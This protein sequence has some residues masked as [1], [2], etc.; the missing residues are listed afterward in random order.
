MNKQL[1]KDETFS[2]KEAEDAIGEDLLEQVVGGRG[3][4]YSVASRDRKRRDTS[5]ATAAAVAP[6][7]EAEP[8]RVFHG[9]PGFSE[10]MQALEEARDRAQ[11]EAQ[12]QMPPQHAQHMA[13]MAS[14]F[15]AHQAD[16]ASL[17][18]HVAEA[19][20][21]LAAEGP[22][23]APS[24]EGGQESTEF[25][26]LDQGIDESTSFTAEADNI[27]SEY[28]AGVETALRLD[29]SGAAIGFGL[30][31]SIATEMAVGSGVTVSATTETALSA[32]AEIM[33]DNG[34]GAELAAEASAAVA[35]E[36]SRQTDL[37]NGAS[38]D[39]SGGVEAFMG[40][41]GEAEGYVGDKGAKFGFDGTAG[42]EYT[43][44]T[45]QTLE[46]SQLTA[47]GEASVS[48]SGTV[49]MA[50]SAEATYEDGALT[51]GAGGGVDALLAGA[52]LGG[53]VSIQFE[54][55]YGTV[56]SA[57]EIRAVQSQLAHF[58]SA[59]DLDEDLTETWREELRDQ[60]KFAQHAADRATEEVE[61]VAEPLVAFDTAVT[62]TIDDLATR[63]AALAETQG[64]VDET[65][66]EL[67]AEFDSDAEF[68]QALEDMRAMESDRIVEAQS[69]VLRGNPDASFGDIARAADVAPSPEMERHFA[70]LEVDAPEP[71]SDAA[72]DRLRAMYDADR[73]QFEELAEFVQQEARAE[74]EATRLSFD[75]AMFTEYMGQDGIATFKETE[76]AKVDL[77]LST[78]AAYAN[79]AHELETRAAVAEQTSYAA[80]VVTANNMVA[81]AD[82]NVADASQ[83]LVSAQER[84]AAAQQAVEEAGRGG[85]KGP[86]LATPEDKAELAA[87]Q[88]AVDHAQKALG[89]AMM[90]QQA[91]YARAD[92]L[93]PDRSMAAVEKMGDALHETAM[94]N[95]ESF[96][97]AHDGA[98]LTRMERDEQR[99]REDMVEFTDRLSD[100][101]NGLGDKLS[102]EA[103][104]F[105]EKGEVLKAQLALLSAMEL[106][107]RGV[108]GY[109]EEYYNEAESVLGE[110]VTE[111]AR[112][113]DVA[114]EEVGNAATTAGNA[115]VDAAT[116]AG[117][118]VADAATTAGNAIADTATTAG[119]AIADTASDAWD[120]ITGGWW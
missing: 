99:I 94:A 13:A 10:S 78:Q 21:R 74:A 68:Q 108:L 35:W 17:P 77:A 27:K 58:D 73:E 96:E 117:N 113:G 34:I 116:T 71:P 49:G 114:I 51:L 31:A 102:A 112:A 44:E 14:Q 82:Q 109:A 33:I 75:K 98:E 46:A 87:A 23:T 63:E 81:A 91:L 92:M 115:V 20:A 15:E 119:N 6:E 48:S 1:R 22:A 41:K 67:R 45:K 70:M 111:M 8:E 80:A 79:I 54:D 118:A 29:S 43:A 88:G 105:K 56:G 52:A 62:G 37:G 59:A 89:Q 38:L 97:E 90:D 32:G 53:S 110:G 24:S 16:A 107:E 60:A 66:A 61:R 85:H 101:S 69:E 64:T 5:H 19:E 2:S 47:T 83:G 50:M 65:R 36:V 95:L 120:G 9:R 72:N 28:A 57:E 7:P 12:A 40:A 11:A 55:K 42:A 86:S 3:R 106:K 103:A 104:E 18:N 30:S 76:T 93:H 26:V 25:T 84:L 39:S 100:A 4:G